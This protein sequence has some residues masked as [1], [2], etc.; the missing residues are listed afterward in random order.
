MATTPITLSKTGANLTG[1]TG[2]ANRTYVIVDTDIITSGMIIFVNGTPLQVGAGN[3]F[4][5]TGSSATITFLNVVDDSDV[6]TITY[7]VSTFPTSGDTSLGTTLTLTKFLHLLK[8]IPNKDSTS[9]EL[10][11]TGDASTTVFWLD[12]LGVL[13]ETYT[14]SYGAAATSTTALTETTHYTIDLDTSKV[15]L[16]SAGVTLVSTNNIYAA[17]S[18][19]STEILNS[20]LLQ[21]LSAAKDQ[22]LQDSEQT[23][24]LSTDDDQAYREIVNEILYGHFNLYQKVFDFFYSPLVKI[25]TTVN[26]AFTLGETTLTLT[27]ASLLP[28][29][30]TIY[31]GGNKVTYTAKSDNDLTVPATTPSIADDAT[32]RGEVIELSVQSEGTAPSYSV[33]DPDT[34]YEIDYDN[35][36]FKIL[37]NAYSTLSVSSTTT[38]S[39]YPQKFKIRV[40]YMHAWHEAGKD[41]TIPDDI[42]Y[43]VLAIAARNLMGRVVA[44]AT[45]YGLNDFSPTLIDVDVQ[46]AKEIIEEY[47]NLNVGTSPY[48]KQS[49]S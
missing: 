10:V 13:D 46:R 18:Y 4:T 30:G 17:Y 39:I 36:R 14:I 31:V 7:F 35:G 11:G 6:I 15:T 26:G 3:D 9:L 16:T 33:L 48:N 42:K 49:L 43:A 24:S 21:A 40:S 28:A 23:F 20:E 8:T 1:T 41:P 5:Y 38:T 19:N 22:L 25:Q 45:E 37:S 2:T 32:V 47:S 44:K 34:E 27:D 29:N 12:Y